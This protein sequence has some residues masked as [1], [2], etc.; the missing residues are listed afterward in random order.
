[1]KSAA[2]D[3][4]PF[5]SVRV[6]V[7]GAGGFIGSHLCRSLLALGADVHGVSR[8][9]AANDGVAWW[10]ADLADPH[11]VH[12][13]MNEVRPGIVFHLA[14]HV[15]GSRDL[16]AVT[17]MLRDNLVTTV[18]ILTAACKTDGPRV[19]LA[20][21][22]EESDAGDAERT[23][24]S[25]YAAA[26]AAGAAYGRM[27]HALYGLP[28]VNLRTF[29]TYGP[30][31]RDGSKL[32]PYVTSSLLRGES[33][34]LS[35]GTREV[36]WIY[37]GDVVDAYLAAALADGVDGT[38]IDIGSGEL[39]TIRAVVEQLAELVAGGAAPLFGAVP[40]RPL[41]RVRRAEVE[42]TREAIGWRPGVPL[43][44]GLARTV[45]WFRERIEDGAWAD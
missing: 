22:M 1:M 10:N 14:S 39:V 11:A 31:Q 30:G 20:G 6:L 13:I 8:R 4:Q 21:S 36:D 15:S 12:G 25:P 18:N 5:A 41:E 7:T 2:M 32:V 34:R 28:V 42:A 35:S 45:A 43:A 40:D 19:L 37:V 23:P 16:A 27:F 24:S 33:P 29:M 44:D 17:P 3:G 38:S 26:K 9:S